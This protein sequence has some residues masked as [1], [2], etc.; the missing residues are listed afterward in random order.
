MYPTFDSPCNTFSSVE[1]L[2]WTSIKFRNLPR[3]VAPFGNYSRILA[4]TCL[5]FDQA[6]QIR[7]QVDAS[8]SQCCFHRCNRSQ[9]CT[10]T[11]LQLSTRCESIWPPIASWHLQT[12]NDLWLRFFSLSFCQSCFLGLVHRDTFSFRR[13][14]YDQFHLFVYLRRHGFPWLLFSSFNQISS[15]PSV[16]ADDSK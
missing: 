11:F 16:T 3:L 12:F 13:L 8:Y 15:P 1:F 10:D 6:A 9:S 2:F 5:H 14:F 4:I 7:T